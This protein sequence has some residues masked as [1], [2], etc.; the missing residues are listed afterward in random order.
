MN[1]ENCG[2][3]QNYAVGRLQL[4]KRRRA[5]VIKRFVAQLRLDNGVPRHMRAFHEKHYRQ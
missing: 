4:F 3:V 2:L 1:F 5:A